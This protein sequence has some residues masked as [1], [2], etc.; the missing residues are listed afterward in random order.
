MEILLIDDHPMLN[1]GIALELEST[2][3]FR[4]CGRAETLA[5]AM[6]CVRKTMPSLV[7]LDLALGEQSGLD[8]LP[9]LKKHCG[10]MKTTMPPVLVCSALDDSFKVRL[11]LDSGAA[12][13]LSK[14]GGKGELLKAIETV[15]SGK[16]YVSKGLDDKLK[17]SADLYAKFTSQEMRVIELIKADKTNAEIAVA[18]FIE[19]KTVENHVSRIYFKTGLSTREEVRRL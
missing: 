1:A 7:V 4:V 10:D 12:G 5:Q 19:K 17:E 3:F 16:R 11:A 9:M 8:F 15:L 18:M 2:G 14:A 13:Y 6:D